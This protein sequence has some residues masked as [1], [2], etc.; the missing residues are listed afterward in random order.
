MNYFVKTAD[1]RYLQSSLDV[2]NSKWTFWL[3]TSSTVKGCTA[4][5]ATPESAEAYRTVAE[6]LVGPLLVVQEER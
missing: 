3:E 2:M 5:H 1:G 6:P 4:C